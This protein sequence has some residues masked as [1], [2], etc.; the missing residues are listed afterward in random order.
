MTSQ[1]AALGDPEAVRAKVAA[2]FAETFN[3]ASLAK[4]LE[5][6]LWNH[7]LK[8][9]QADHVPLEWTSTFARSFRERYTSRALGLDLY[10]L[11]INESLRSQLQSGELPLK[12][13][14]AMTPYEMKPALWEPI[15]EKIAAK[16]LRNQSRVDPDTMPDGLLECRKCKS[17]KTTYFQMQTRSADEPMTV[18]ASCLKCGNR[19][20]Q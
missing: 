10:N 18:F 12:K 11:K 4:K 15:F 1:M 7:T 13:F 9:C 14:V 19:W 20:K 2:R 5:I 6:V 17:K 3:D 8:K 16:N